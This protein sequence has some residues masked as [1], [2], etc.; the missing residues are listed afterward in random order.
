MGPSLSYDKWQKSSYSNGGSGNC[1]ETRLLPGDQVAA[2]D[3][4]D[5]AKG[6]I[7]VSHSAWT[8]FVKAVKGQKI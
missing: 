6:A 4:K 5:V 7:A 2:R 3:S 8:A 1:I